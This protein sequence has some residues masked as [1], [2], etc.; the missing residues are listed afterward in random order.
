M[1][2]H[3]PGHYL[4]NDMISGDSHD[5][6]HVKNMSDTDK[7]MDAPSNKGHQMDPNSPDNPMNW[8]AAKKIYTSLS[9]TFL[10][11]A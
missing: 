10:V 3:H 4:N 1:S 7:M 11:F 2:E 9:S 6:E 5:E 8:L